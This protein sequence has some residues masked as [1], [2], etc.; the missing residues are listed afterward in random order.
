MFYRL[1]RHR[2]HQDMLAAELANIK[3]L[4]FSSSTLGSLPH[5]NG[6]IRETLR[7]HPAVPT[8][9]MRVS[10]KDVMIGDKMIPSST[11]I[12]APRWS[13]GQRKRDPSAIM[14]RAKL[15][16]LRRAL[17]MLRISCPR[18]GTAGPAW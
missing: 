7:L 6:V 12:C 18:D 8:A 16:Q 5:L 1:A 9:G 11:A 13:I 10:T 3:C 14:I 2:E 17:K 4:E 15:Q